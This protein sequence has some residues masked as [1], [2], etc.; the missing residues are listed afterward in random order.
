MLRNKVILITG[1]S[2][3]IGRATALL[4]ALRHAKVIINY[5]RSEKE[6]E[7]VVAAILR[8]GQEAIKIKADVSC[9]SEVKEMFSIIK[10]KYGKI[11]VLVNNAGIMK[12]NL[13]L[14][15]KTEEFDELIGTNCKGVFLCIRAAA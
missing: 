15:T 6:A 11:D 10:D 13:L 9:E 5:N 12:S 2:R 7:E 1:A 4:L 14:M 3:G 8:I